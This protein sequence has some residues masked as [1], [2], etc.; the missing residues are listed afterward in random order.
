ML[1][2]ENRFIKK[3]EFARTRKHGRA[4]SSGNIELK[5]AE[6]RLNKA[7]IGVV[8]GLN[9]SKKSTERNKAKRWVR[10]FFRKNLTKI[11]KSTNILVI[12]KKK[13]PEKTTKKQIE[14]SIEKALE[15]AGLDKP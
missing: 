1:P 9:F 7:K 14:N 8:V 12:V 13:D 6:N 5:I 4:Y 15:K 10:D 2:P 11:K 3:S